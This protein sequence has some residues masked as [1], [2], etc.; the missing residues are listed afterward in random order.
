M[1]R[2]REEWPFKEQEDAARLSDG[3]TSAGV[4]LPFGFDPASKDRMAGNEI[5]SLILGHTIRARNIDDAG[6]TATTVFAADG[7]ASLT[8]AGLAMNG[9]AVPDD[10]GVCI[11]WEKAKGC[12]VI[13]RN[14]NGSRDQGDEFIWITEWSR[15]A[16][17][18]E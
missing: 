1:V 3:L 10:Q 11:W 16:F 13:F 18:V 15:W 4:G 6:E 9:Y 12:A 5:K 8:Q 7:K 2:A 17:I 14:P